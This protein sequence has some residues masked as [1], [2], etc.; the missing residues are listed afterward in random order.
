LSKGGEQRWLPSALL[1]HHGVEAIRPAAGGCQ[2]K[3]GKAHLDRQGAVVEQREETAREMADEI[4]KR[5]LA[6]QDE[7]DRPRK[8]PE[9]QEPAKYQFEGARSPDQRE[10]LDLIE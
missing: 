3:T 2:I 4:G 5:H 10:T 9:H 1:S 7:C 6:R 8:Q